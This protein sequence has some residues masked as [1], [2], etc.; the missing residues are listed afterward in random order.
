[1]RA[2]RVFAPQILGLLATTGFATGVAAA[3]SRVVVIV[4]LVIL[5]IAVRDALE[6]LLRMYAEPVRRAVKA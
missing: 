2:L 5:G 1:M 4:P 3:G 6:W